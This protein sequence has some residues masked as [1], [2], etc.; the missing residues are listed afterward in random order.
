MIFDFEEFEEAVH[1]GYD[2]NS[3]FRVMFD[4]TKRYEIEYIPASAER[5][6]WASMNAKQKGATFLPH[7][8]KFERSK[9]QASI[10]MD[11]LPLRLREI[12]GHRELMEKKGQ[13]IIRNLLLGLLELRNHKMVLKDI[14]P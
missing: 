10:L 11:V 5:V 9:M 7:Y 4:L 12:I 3:Q 14:N 2:L 1:S 8:Q 6:L 13:K